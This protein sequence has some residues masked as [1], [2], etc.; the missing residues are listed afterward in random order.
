MTSRR[1][2]HL[3]HRNVFAQVGE[4]HRLLNAEIGVP[5]DFG[6]PHE[7]ARQ[8]VERLLDFRCFGPVGQLWR[9]PF[10][11]GLLS[12]L[13]RRLLRDVRREAFGA[14]HAPLAEALHHRAGWRTERSAEVLNW[15]LARPNVS[16]RTSQ[17]VDGRERSRGYAVVRVVGE[18]AVLVDLQLGDERSGEFGDLL[19]SVSRDLDGTGVTRLELRAPSSGL[20]A[21]RARE[22]FGFAAEPSDTTLEVRAMDPA[23]DLE[24]AG[25]LFDYRALD[26]DIY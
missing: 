18:R 9:P 11:G 19:D 4:T 2:R 3:G 24:R 13:R 25:T 20:L 17:L 22:E 15:R 26:H 1:A 12:R 7:H 16:Y 8:V 5:F 21:R 10:R 6:F 23:V 14:A